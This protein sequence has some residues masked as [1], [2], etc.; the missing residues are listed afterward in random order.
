M[1]RLGSKYGKALHFDFCRLTERSSRE[2]ELNV[3]H[4]CM[5]ELRSTH[6]IQLLKRISSMKFAI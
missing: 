6:N 3:Y 5:T 1:E 2:G 4:I